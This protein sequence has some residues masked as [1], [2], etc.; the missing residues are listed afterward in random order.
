MIYTT[1]CWT[2]QSRCVASACRAGGLL[3]GVQSSDEHADIL[4]N[5]EAAQKHLEFIESGYL[6]ALDA[7]PA[8]VTGDLESAPPPQPPSAAA[9][10]ANA[11]ASQETGAAKKEKKRHEPKLGHEFKAKVRPFVISEITANG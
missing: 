6:R 5:L 10:L 2:H 1:N 3:T 8:S 4:T 9:T 11:L 7:L